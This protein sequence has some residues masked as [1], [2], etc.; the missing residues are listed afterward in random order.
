MDLT[1]GLGGVF[2]IV[3]GGGHRFV[4]GVRIKVHGGTRTYKTG[5]NLSI[6]CKI[7]SKMAKF[8]RSRLRRSRISSFMFCRETRAKTW[9][10]ESPVSRILNNTRRDGGARAPTTSSR[11]KRAQCTRNDHGA[12][13]ATA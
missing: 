2:K 3:G 13:R 10:R 12:E 5:E 4:R 6:L 8:S 1:F 9:I 11:K 7:M